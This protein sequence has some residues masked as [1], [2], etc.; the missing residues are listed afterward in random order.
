MYNDDDENDDNFEI[1]N[2][3]NSAYIDTS[4]LTMYLDGH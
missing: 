4:E 2:I 1:P 3:D